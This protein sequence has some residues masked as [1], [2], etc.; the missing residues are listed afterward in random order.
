MMFD[1][2]EKIVG[3][4]TLTQ[5]VTFRT[6]PLL[7]YQLHNYAPSE[8][9]F[10][11]IEIS[12]VLFLFGVI[13]VYVLPKVD[14][15]HDVA[16]SARQLIGMIRGVSLAASSSKQ[17]YTLYFDLD[18]RAYWAMTLDGQSERRPSNSALAGRIPLPDQIRFLNITTFR[19][20]TLTSGVASIRFLP[21]GRTERAVIRL[22]NQSA[23]VLTLVLNPLTGAV[24]VLEGSADPEAPDPIPDRLRPIVVPPPS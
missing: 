12:L 19:Q 21:V 3:P 6:A 20:G 17:T 15:S 13:L 18:Q 11:L 10:T 2:C 4:E 23:A 8:K 22:G 1:P 9:G 7:S 5:R 16:S 14:R 24:R